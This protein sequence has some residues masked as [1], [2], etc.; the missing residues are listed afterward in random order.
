[1]RQRQ[2]GRER[3]G[4]ME[5]KGGTGPPQTGT[6]HKSPPGAFENQLR[7]HST[8]GLTGP[9]AVLLDAVLLD[10]LRSYSTCFP[11]EIFTH[12]GERKERGKSGKGAKR[13]RRAKGEKSGKRGKRG[14]MDSGL[15]RRGQ[16]RPYARTHV[17]MPCYTTHACYATHALT[18]T[19]RTHACTHAYTHTV[20]RSTPAC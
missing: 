5:G 10:H 1:M 18:H 4:G 14:Q 12:L 2:G 17:H 13:G 16:Q 20:V 9:I 8:C 7:S 11:P 6:T 15:I 3:E 19:P